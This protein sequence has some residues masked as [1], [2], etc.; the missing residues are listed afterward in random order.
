MMGNWGGEGPLAS[1]PFGLNCEGEHS[2]MSGR[3]FPYV[4]GTVCDQARQAQVVLTL[5]DECLEWLKIRE[6]HLAKLTFC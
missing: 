5:K 4:R 6:T 1:F 2:G 3:V